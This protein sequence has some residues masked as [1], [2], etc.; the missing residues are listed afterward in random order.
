MHFAACAGD[1]AVSQPGL[2]SPPLLI[3]SATHKAFPGTAAH[4]QAC[5]SQ[6]DHISH[7]YLTSHLLSSLLCTSFP[8]SGGWNPPP[9]RV[10]GSL[11]V[12]PHVTQK[13][14]ADLSPLLSVPS[15]LSDCQ[16]GV[17]VCRGRVRVRT[18]RRLPAEKYCAFPRYSE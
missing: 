16:V 9:L 11:P 2:S 14:Q 13:R 1:S 10:C 7:R 15:V 17:S 12:R 8:R 4:C 5:F 3:F 6:K 18:R